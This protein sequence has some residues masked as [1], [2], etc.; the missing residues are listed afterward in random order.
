MPST[1]PGWLT[2]AEAL[3]RYGKHGLNYIAIR[4]FVKQNQ[5]STCNFGPAQKRPRIHL[6]V[7]ELEAWK[8]GGIEAV[9]PVKAAYE[10]SRTANV[11]A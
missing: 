5:F 4:R 9:A 10:A 11:G 6:R 2:P 7:K 3:K 8:T 1:K